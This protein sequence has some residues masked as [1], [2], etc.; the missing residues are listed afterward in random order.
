MD[1]EKIKGLVVAPFTPM[2]KN[3]R[4][5]LTVIPSLHELYKNNK[6]TGAF[7]NGSTGEG[8]ELTAEERKSLTEA[9]DDSVSDNFKLLVH[10]GHSSLEEAKALAS[11]AG[12]CNSVDGISTVGP[13]YRKPDSVERLVEFCKEVAAAAPDTPFYYY[14][15][16]PLTGVDLPMFDF[17]E[18]AAEEI[19]TL[20]GIKFS[21]N[22]F[23]DFS[24]CLQY[25]KGSFD[26]IFGSD[27]LMSCG[28][29][30]GAEGF[31]GST[32]NLFPWLYHQIFEAFDSGNMTEVRRLQNQ[33]M[34]Y[35]RLIDQFGYAAAAKRL[36]KR[37]G[38]DCGPARLPLHTPTEEQMDELESVLRE[39]DFFSYALRKVNA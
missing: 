28:L 34:N 36:M 29:M 33:S 2:H 1:T 4:I 14:H 20:A 38:V 35:V 8:L 10:V 31:I 30:L 27:E 9:W 26:L 39:E 3:G 6:V 7:I 11:H 37:L 5:N 12:N 17:L 25:K 13:F 16:P 22:N 21:H 24:R 32:Y 15:I 18:L 19:P 23:V